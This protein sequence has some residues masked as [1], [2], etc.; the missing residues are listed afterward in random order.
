MQGLLAQEAR[1]AETA[2]TLAELT[3]ALSKARGFL[4][5]RGL[6]AAFH[7]Q[8]LSYGEDERLREV[9]SPADGVSSPHEPD[10]VLLHGEA[11]CPYLQAGKPCPYGADCPYRRRALALAA[12]A[13]EGQHAA[14]PADLVHDALMDGVAAA[15]RAVAGASSALRDKLRSIDGDE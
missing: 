6:Y 8:H 4:R 13:R 11:E 7:A 10:E 14:E 9:V 2:A 5:E 12:E 1:A 3:N 15:A